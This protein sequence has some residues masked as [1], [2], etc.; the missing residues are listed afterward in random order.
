MHTMMWP[1][2]FGV[3]HQRNTEQ[4]LTLKAM[5]NFCLCIIKVSYETTIG[6]VMRQNQTSS[7]RN[8]H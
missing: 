2:L 3:F 6:L 5:G 7:P 4:V 8:V 1:H